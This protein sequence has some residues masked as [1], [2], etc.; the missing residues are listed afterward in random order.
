M[1]YNKHHPLSVRYSQSEHFVVRFILSYFYHP[2]SAWEEVNK[3]YSVRDCPAHECFGSVYAFVAAESG[4]NA[5]LCEM[6]GVRAVG[7]LFDFHCCCLLVFKLDYLLS[8]LEPLLL[9]GVAAGETVALGVAPAVL[10]VHD[11][12]GGVVV[13]VCAMLASHYCHTTRR[14]SVVRLPALW[15]WC[16]ACQAGLAVHSAQRWG[17]SQSLGGLYR[18]NPRQGLG[19]R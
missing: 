17:F 16:A 2:P 5:R 10:A 1:L 12:G 13:P 3:Y 4:V 7:L 15:L 18:R 9:G 14:F 11:V 8:F 19:L 6:H